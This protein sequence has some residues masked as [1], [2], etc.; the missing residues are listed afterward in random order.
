L[1]DVLPKEV[2]EKLERLVDDCFCLDLQAVTL[3][4]EA[5]VRK[6]KQMQFTLESNC[7]YDEILIQVVNLSMSLYEQF[8]ELF[9]RICRVILAVSSIPYSNNQNHWGN[10]STSRA[11]SRNGS[12]FAA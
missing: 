9:S 7:S 6:R 10:L 2:G 11:E 4:R 8:K 1:E 3:V 12:A 5:I